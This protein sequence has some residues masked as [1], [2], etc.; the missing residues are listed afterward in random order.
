MATYDDAFST[1]PHTLRLT[2]TQTSQ[3]IAANTSLV[4]WSL[5]AIKHPSY[6]SYSFYA[7]PWAVTINGSSGSGTWTY[8]FRSV[9]SV[10]LASGSITVPH[11]ADG[12]K[13]ISVSASA[14]GSSIGD[15]SVSGTLTLTTIPRA[16]TPT[17]SANPVDA[18]T[19]VTVTTNRASATF[20]HEIDYSI[21][22]A[23]GSVGTG[24]GASTSWTPPLSLLNQIP[25]STTGVVTITTRTY[26]G[27]T[28]IGTTT[29]SLTISAPSTVVPDFDTITVS[30][31]VT[32]VATEVAA[33]VK[34]LSKLNLAITS[35]VGAY[36]STISSYRITLP[37]TT[38]NAVSGVSNFLT[39][40]GTVTIT[41][42]ITDSRGRTKTKTV[43]I[44]VLD[45]V[46]PSLDPA[47]FFVRRSDAVGTLEEE[48]TYLRV[49]LKAD[50]ASLIN[51]TQRNALSYKLYTRLRGATTWNLV[52]NETPGG[53]SFNSF[54]VIGTYDVG[55]SYELRVE[56]LDKF[57]M[58]VVETT[59]A[60]ASV[61]MHWSDG[62]ALGKFWEQGGLDVLTQI[63]QNNGLAV[64][65]VGDV[66]TTS[67]KGIIELATNAEVQTGTDAERAVTPASLSARTATT[68]RSGVVELATTAETLAMSDA[69]RAVTP[70]GLD[71]V[72]G[73]VPVIPTAGTGSTVDASGLVTLNGTACDVFAC[74]SAD[75]DWYRIEMD[76]ATSAT[77]GLYL[78]L[79]TSGGTA[80]TGN[81]E[82]GVISNGGGGTA[83]AASSTGQAQW[84]IDGGAS[85]ELHWGTFDIFRPFLAS[86]TRFDGGFTSRRAAG[87][88]SATA[89]RGG[90]HTDPSSYPALR[91]LASGGATVTGTLRIYG[92][93]GA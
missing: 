86:S 28:L 40:S 21:G 76:L 6:S 43:N 72:V 45:Y 46:V 9:S 93:K 30:E 57:A 56:I 47:L 16:S 51:S 8:D 32:L 20:T 34:S 87:P 75:Y 89:K 7:N 17:F 13:T 31:N 74:F 63:Y 70:A 61:F 85:S 84:I 35:A 81:Y 11:N 71:R 69:D 73:F 55:E 65:D 44:T 52:A 1:R 90:I 54:D 5:V 58:G 78:R 10:T 18:G 19:A 33:Y 15:A 88:I 22:A 23:S 92:Y 42:L 80:S 4:S 25:N 12:T 26:S 14:T 48:G 77:Q 66:A 68:S 41:G 83:S 60:T 64:V 82:H 38:I 67:A 49:D 3:D 50:V 53:I 2:V 62:L 79:M 24:I 39:T 29:T 37:G 36:G 27:A 91:F 59:V